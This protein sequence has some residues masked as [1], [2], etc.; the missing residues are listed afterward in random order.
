MHRFRFAI[1]LSTAPSKKAWHDLARKVEDLGYSTLYVP[2]HFDDQ[3]APMIA[4]AVAAE[5]TTTLNVGTLV[6]DNDYRHPFVLAKEAATLDLLTEG[7]YEFGIGAGWMK[8]DYESSGIAYDSPGVRVDRLIEALEVFRQL[9]NDGRCTFDGTHY[10]ITDAVQT[11]M[12]ITPGG[13]PLVLGGGSKR[14]LTLAASVADI[15]SVVPSLKAGEIGLEMAPQAAPAR[16]DERAEWIRAA[17]AGRAS[18]PEIQAWTMFAAV[19]DDEATLYEQFSALFGLPAEEIAE[20]PVGLVGSV[21]SII[22]KLEARRERWGFSY[23]VLHE[24]EIEAF[25]PVVAALSGR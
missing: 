8:T 19:T 24:A 5:A 15:V 13:P 4:C 21:E 17:A 25:A 10:H 14:V 23:I 7:R 9:F 6:L 12:P 18:A 1:Q 16:Y 2:D 3:L 11:P 20:S 22:D